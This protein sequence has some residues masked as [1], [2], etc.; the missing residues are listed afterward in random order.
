MANYN[1]LP[2]RSITEASFADKISYSYGIIGYCIN[3]KKWLMAQRKYSHSFILILL[4]HY[5]DANLP[6]MVKSLTKDEIQ[7][8]KDLIKCPDTL[9]QVKDKYLPNWHMFEEVDNFECLEYTKERLNSDFLSQQIYTTIGCDDTEWVWPRGK[10]HNNEDSISCACR[11]VE[12]EVGLII[13][14][15][16]MIAPLPFIHKSKTVSGKTYISKYWLCVF[17]DEQEL[18]IDL[19]QDEIKC[20]AWL[21]E[22]QVREKFDDSKNAIIDQVKQVLNKWK[23]Q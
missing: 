20:C 18:R 17:Q 2:I 5:R 21:D 6:Q 23:L 10:P 9:T 15:D 4:G 7:V 13:N 16:A 22:T 3:K 14:N 19:N 12:E 8:I 11:E 1:S